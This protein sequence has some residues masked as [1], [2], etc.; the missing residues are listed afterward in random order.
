MK[1]HFAQDTIFYVLLMLPIP[2]WLGLFIHDSN[3][4][5]ID[6]YSLVLLILVLPMLEEIF[7]RGLLQPWLATK[8]P[9]KTSNI[10]QANIMT[11]SVFALV[12]LFAQPLLLALCTFIPSMIFG[13]AKE[14]YSRLL[15]SIILHSSYNGGYLLLGTK[16]LN[17]EIMSPI[18]F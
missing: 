10:T 17:N 18:L 5:N 7:F 16:L 6:G 13:F 11:S 4:E 9:A 8:Y 12:H 1:G 14:R 2:L 3:I 15:P